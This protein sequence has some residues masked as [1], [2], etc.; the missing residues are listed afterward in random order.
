MPQQRA[1]VKGRRTR[2]VGG[3][4]RRNPGR[5][6]CHNRGSIPRAPQIE[7]L[8]L[9]ACASELD[10]DIFV[11]RWFLA[12]LPPG[13]N[14]VS[15]LTRNRNLLGAILMVHRDSS[16]PNL[17]QVPEQQAEFSRSFCR[18]RLRYDSVVHF[19]VV[20]SNRT[21]NTF[22][23]IILLDLRHAFP[24]ILVPSLVTD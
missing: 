1:R 12:G 6:K 2:A 18:V 13:I 21:P 19:E 14:L 9:V 11:S 10:L 15:G 20:S 4:D 7:S 16:F 17:K 8:L 24:E 23:H 3:R 5:S 22:S